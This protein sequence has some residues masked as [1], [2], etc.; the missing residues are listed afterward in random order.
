MTFPNKSTIFS[1]KKRDQ[2]ELL[3]SERYKRTF[4]PEYSCLSSKKMDYNI[5][6][7]NKIMEYERNLST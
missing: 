1:K 4:I 6:Y 2:K 7:K 5:I 3:I